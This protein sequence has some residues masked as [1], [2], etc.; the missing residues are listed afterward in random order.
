MEKRILGLILLV[1][2]IS[3]LRGISAYHEDRW[4]TIPGAIREAF[5]FWVKCWVGLAIIGLGVYSVMMMSGLA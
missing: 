4:E 5:W 3:I 1:T 2:I